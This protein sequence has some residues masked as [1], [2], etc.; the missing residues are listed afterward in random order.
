MAAPGSE[1]GE[2][3]I[4]PRPRGRP[5]ASTRAVKN[6]SF[7]QAMARWPSAVPEELERDHGGMRGQR[8]A[9][10]PKP[11]DRYHVAG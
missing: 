9:G 8:Q 5:I 11:E 10:V 7:G 6:F 1:R 2:A 4:A 3:R